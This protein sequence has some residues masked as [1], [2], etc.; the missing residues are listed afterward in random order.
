MDGRGS[1]GT[2]RMVGR[3]TLCLHKRAA[4][5]TATITCQRRQQELRIPTS[6]PHIVQLLPKQSWIL[7]CSALLKSRIPV[8]EQMKGAGMNR[9]AQQQAHHCLPAPVQAPAPVQHMLLSMAFPMAT[10]KTDSSESWHDILQKRVAPCST[11]PIYLVQGSGFAYKPRCPAS[12]HMPCTEPRHLARVLQLHPG[13]WCSAPLHGFC[14][15]H[16]KYSTRVL[17]C[18]DAGLDL[19]L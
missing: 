15:E 4:T 17:S 5:P 10:F 13:L 11:I 19:P 2:R 12:L 6:Q 16:H 18:E 7:G 1:L 9:V 14:H 3:W 8:W